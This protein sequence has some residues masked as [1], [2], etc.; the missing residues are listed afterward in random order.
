MRSS[1]WV[2]EFWKRASSHY[3]LCNSMV[4]WPVIVT[5]SFIMWFPTVVTVFMIKKNKK[6]I[7]VWGLGTAFENGCCLSLA[8]FLFHLTP[9]ANCTLKGKSDLISLTQQYLQSFPTELRI[10]KILWFLNPSCGLNWLK[11]WN[12]GQNVFLGN[13]RQCF[14]LTEKKE[15]DRQPLK[16]KKEYPRLY[17][18]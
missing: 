9:L 15:S 1:I 10:L 3:C 6:A 14:I 18:H 13:F 4:Q 17:L 12:G 5:I 16:N 2:L 7:P 8:L 11:N